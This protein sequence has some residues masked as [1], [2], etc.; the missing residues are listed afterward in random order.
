MRA[1]REQN[2]IT[3]S[4][5]AKEVHALQAGKTIIDRPSVTMMDAKVE[6]SPLSAI[7]EDN[8]GKYRYSLDRLE[9]GREA[10]IR[11]MLYPDGDLVIFIPKIKLS[12]VRIAQAILPKKKIETPL[13]PNRDEI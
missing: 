6:V 7:E 1:E 8:S 4:L 9:K 10:P 13:S 2:Q 12:D 5:T 3:I 11:G